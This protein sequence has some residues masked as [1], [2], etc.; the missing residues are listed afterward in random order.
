MNNKMEFFSILPEECLTKIHSGTWGL[1]VCV[2]VP[3]TALPVSFPRPLASLL[4]E[5]SA[6]LPARPMHRAVIQLLSLIHLSSWLCRCARS[7]VWISAPCFSFSFGILYFPCSNSCP[8]LGYRQ[9]VFVQTYY[10][11]SSRIFSGQ[12]IISVLTTL[13]LYWLHPMFRNNLRLI[14]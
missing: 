2:L 14:K 8:S 9:V 11:K 13:L 7:A 6:S 1:W 12:E 4:D 10:P 3:R 5:A